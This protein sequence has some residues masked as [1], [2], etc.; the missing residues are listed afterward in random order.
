MTL[1]FYKYTMVFPIFVKM[2]D[3]FHLKLVKFQS[4][5]R[6]VYIVVFRALG[7]VAILALDLK[8]TRHFHVTIINDS[9]PN[10]R[11]M[12]SH[13]CQVLV[14]MSSGLPL[15]FQLNLPVN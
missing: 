9:G 4:P 13:N 3:M 15:I 11:S 2:A 8:R 10:F 1:V 14:V 5:S 12:I 7:T 6:F